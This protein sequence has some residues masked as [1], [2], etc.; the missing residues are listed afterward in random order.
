MRLFLPCLFVL[1]SPSVFAQWIRL[2]NDS[3]RFADHINMHISD[4]NF[5]GV[6]G[7][8]YV[9]ERNKWYL[10]TDGDGHGRPTYLF[11]IEGSEKDSFPRW[12]NA[13]AVTVGQV[14]GL[15][16]AE[17]IRFD[18]KNFWVCT[19]QGI[20]RTDNQVIFEEGSIA[21]LSENA[22]SVETPLFQY[23]STLDNRGYESLALAGQDTIATVSEWPMTGDGRY[24]RLKQM[25]CNNGPCQT[26]AEY[27]YELDINSC[28][29]NGVALNG[30][31]GNGISEIL[32]IDNGRYLVLE[33][34]FDGQRISARLYETRISPENTNVAGTGF[35]ALEK[36]GPFRPLPKQEVFNFNSIAGLK[37]DNLEGMTWGPDRKSI[38]LVSDNNYQ[39]NT[40]RQKTQWLVL[41][42]VN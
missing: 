14:L 13:A 26:L 27:A 29:G 3:T 12:D 9:Q 30:S 19:E 5:G 21:R 25:N 33:R 39:K 6:S 32:Y 11:E 17:A 1:I 18:K 7:I 15:T 24:V 10:I 35:E 20:P 16:Q 23:T 31:E 4:P 37:I 8:E 2:E 40:A 42:V 41:K 28:V 22:S 38:V 36:A 34:C